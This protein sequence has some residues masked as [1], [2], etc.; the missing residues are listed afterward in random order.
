MAGLWVSL[1]GII[2][3]Y[4]YL[5]HTRISRRVALR[6]LILGHSLCLSLVFLYVA[7]VIIGNVSYLPHPRPAAGLRLQPL[8]GL[9]SGKQAS[10]FF[11]GR[12]MQR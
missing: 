6:S 1:N 9:P 12:W 4:I 11:Q 2:Y 10:P 3:L 8:S 5:L 7:L